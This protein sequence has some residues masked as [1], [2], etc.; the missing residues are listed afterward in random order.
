MEMPDI[1]VDRNHARKVFESAVS[2]IPSDQAIVRVFH[3]V[4]GQGKSA[5]AEELFRGAQ[6]KSDLKF[7]FIDAAK[8]VPDKAPDPD[9]FLIMIRNAFARSGV[10]FPAFDLAFGLMWRKVRGDREPPPMENAWLKWASDAANVA[11]PDVIKLTVKLLGESALSVPGVGWLASTGTRWF[12]D[13]GKRAWLFQ[14]RECL[15]LLYRNNELVPDVELVAL[16]PRILAEDMRSYVESKERRRLVLFVDEYERIFEGAGAGAEFSRNESDRLLRQIV[17]NA[18]GL[19]VVFFSRNRLVWENDPVWRERLANSHTELDG[20]PESFADEWLRKVPVPDERL[21][22]IMINNSCE[23]LEGDRSVYPLLLRLQ[24]EHWL[25]VAETG[26]DP[27]AALTISGGSF[28]RR[29]RQIVDRLLGD[30]PHAMQ[31]LL[32]ALAPATRFDLRLFE[33]VCR[34]LNLPFDLFDN[35]EHLSIVSSTDGR[36]WKMHRVVADVIC[37][38]V[39]EKRLQ[40]AIDV[41]SAH[42]EERANPPTP[43]EVD[44]DAAICLDEALRLRMR[45]PDPGVADW[46]TAAC[47]MIHRSGRHAAVE[48]LWSDCLTACRAT[49]GELHRDTAISLSWL[50]CSLDAQGR[51]AD[52][53]TLHREALRILGELGLA[54]KIDAARARSYLANC[55]CEIATD[56]GLQEAAVLQSDA[57]AYYLAELGEDELETS[58]AYFNM[59]AIDKARRRLEPAKINARKALTVRLERLGDADLATA[60]SFTQTAIVLDLMWQDSQDPLLQ[61]EA[62]ELHEN[63]VSVR[64][65]L[66]GER[67]ALTAESR[68][69]LAVHLNMRGLYA[70]AGGQFFKAWRLFRSALGPRHPRT[71]RCLV[72]LGTNLY[73][74]GNYRRAGR[75]YRGARAILAISLGPRHPLVASSG[76]NIGKVA[77][78][79]G[80]DLSN[81]AIPELEQASAIFAEVH[82]ADHFRRQACDKALEEARALVSGM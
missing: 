37:E 59:A 7:E 69:A 76:Y 32:L 61:E 64:T 5:L 63:A 28:E 75:A 65:R 46:L 56:S 66:L 40:R 80:G 57:L 41:L 31:S 14:N 79:I 45:R 52:A 12:V 82:P 22:R 38:Y 49:L 29:C 48:R 20:L 71:G 47:T 34:Q 53:E 44:D 43:S 73:L 4:G 27:I 6:D 39:G 54:E 16:M 25:N 26:A 15:K 9:L 11:G 18:G 68:E 81:S 17:E 1:F 67:H 2:R 78:K 3:G 58:A 23:T 24:V 72:N 10:S 62:L 51:Y 19:L 70:E 55:L 50:A 33:H 30:Y 42:F 35:L 74:A 8:V 36:W 13:R 21:R 60:A 77:M